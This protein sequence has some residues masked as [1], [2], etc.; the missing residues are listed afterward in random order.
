M[1]LFKKREKVAPS[2]PTDQQLALANAGLIPSAGALAPSLTAHSDF[3]KRATCVRC[4][5]PKRLP[6]ITA[7]LYC[8]Y[9]GTLVD[10][11]FRIANAG[12]N[13]ALTN[14]IYAQLIAPWQGPPLAQAIAVGDRD[15]HRGIMLQVYREWLLAA[16]QAASPRAK[17]HG[18][19]RA[20]HHPT[21]SS[22]SS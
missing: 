2:P 7:Y 14:T 8:D 11:D 9:C 1:A 15:G 19:P 16:R 13:E 18:V 4:G 6:S 17:R 22:A 10:Y 20:V 21:R 3:V 12:M 5:G